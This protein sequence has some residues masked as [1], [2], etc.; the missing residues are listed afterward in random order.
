MLLGFHSRELR[1]CNSEPSVLDNVLETGV[2]MDRLI[3][4]ADFRKAAVRVRLGEPRLGDHL[5]ISSSGSSSVFFA[6]HVCS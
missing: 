5:R 1:T 3:L 6:A 2:E 4:L